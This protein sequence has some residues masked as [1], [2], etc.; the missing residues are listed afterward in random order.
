MSGVSFL[1]RS[2]HTYA[3]APY[4]DITE[5]EYNEAMLVFP[6]TIDWDVLA[7]YERGDT[8][9]GSQTLACSGDTCELVD[10]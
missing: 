4:Q 7:L 6:L 2:D 3:Q 10:F 1:P 8:T 9:A 5:E